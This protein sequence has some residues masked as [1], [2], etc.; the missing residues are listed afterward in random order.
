MQDF[1]YI[2]QDLGY[3]MQDLH[4]IMWDLDLCYAMWESV[5]DLSL[6]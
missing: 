6:Q 1:H 5:V 2:M 4:Y 3:I